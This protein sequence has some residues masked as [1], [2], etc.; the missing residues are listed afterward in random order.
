MR[1]S[2]RWQEGGVNA[3]YTPTSPGYFRSFEMGDLNTEA[4]K[5]LQPL[6]GGYEPGFALSADFYSS[7]SIFEADLSEIFFCSWIYAAHV[8][9]L[10]D[11]GSYL[12]LE[13]GAE[14]IILVRDS[15][16]AIR[17]FANV[18]RHRG[19]RIC[20]ETSGKVRAFVCPY[21]AWTYEL[22]GRLRSRRSMAPGFDQSGYGLKRLSV[23][24]FHGLVFVNLDPDAPDFSNEV[25]EVNSGLDI[26][27]LENTRV[28]CQE[29][30]TV[31]A[32]WKLAI[33][34][35]MECYHCA[36]AHAEYSRV[37]ALKSPKDNEAL[38][39]KMLEEAKRLGYST[40]SVDNSMPRGKQ[41]VGYFYARNAL[42]PPCVTGSENGEPVAPLLGGIKEY[43]GGVADI[44]LGP[45]S[46]GILYPDHAVLYR[47]L[48]RDIQKTDMDIVWLVRED[49][50]P[51]RDYDQDQLTW[52]WRVTTEAD[53]RIILNNQKGVN[54]RFYEPGPLS[55]METFTAAF[56]EW[57]LE[58]IS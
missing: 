36:P 14:S 46:Y 11:S 21:H 41:D 33:E 2:K 45:A 5:E 43:G 1:F 30:Y 35:F 12:L 51:G 55:E 20:T 29:T 13:I 22:D 19:S 6:I 54:S 44:Q 57:Y 40:G 38:R 18:C 56:I 52:L 42:Y 37:H 7:R 49:A 9:Q 23:S 10:A 15:D 50:A 27:G 58:R 47:F 39:P 48:P 17:A 34:N 16:D 32:N 24:V 4:R 26:Y 31:D 3:A 8:S 53:K 28:A 25:S